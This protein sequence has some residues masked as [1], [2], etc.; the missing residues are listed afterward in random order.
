MYAKKIV[1]QATGQQ[2]MPVKDSEQEWN[3]F[4]QQELAKGIYGNESDIELIE[5]PPEFLSLKRQ[6]LI[7]RGNINRNACAAVLAFVTGYNI[8]RS[9]SEEDT[10]TMQTQFADIFSML[11]A[12]RATSALTLISAVVV[13]GNIATQELKDGCIEVMK[14]FGIEL[15]E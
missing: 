14:E 1:N 11:L 8:D 3:E 5:N 2:F 9:L 7:D 15:G 10:Q 6:Q 4:Y 12:G 13:D